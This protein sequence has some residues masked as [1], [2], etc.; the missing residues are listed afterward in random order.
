MGFVVAC[1]G[2]VAA[3]VVVRTATFACLNTNIHP[4]YSL[5][6]ASSRNWLVH[7]KY[8]IIV[9]I[10]D[11]IPKMIH[12]MIPYKLAIKRIPCNRRE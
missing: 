8:R 2:D 7:N 3:L 11:D 5:I 10:Q 4:M 9:L 6:R 12:K 1:G